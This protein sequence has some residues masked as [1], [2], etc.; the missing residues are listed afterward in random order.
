MKIDRI[1]S[2]AFC[3]GTLVWSERVKGSPKYDPIY[4]HKH[5]E[6]KYI[7]G[8][9]KERSEVIVHYQPQPDKL[10]KLRL[11]N[12]ALTKVLRAYA[13]ALEAPKGT[14]IPIIRSRYV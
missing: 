10:L 9:T 1:N 12:I 11:K 8:I 14:V 13:K 7:T 3:S 4:S 2:Q 5:L 6:A